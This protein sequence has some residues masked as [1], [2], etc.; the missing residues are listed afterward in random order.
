MCVEELD[1]SPENY[2]QLKSKF[3][4]SLGPCNQPLTVVRNKIESFVATRKHSV[5][6]SDQPH[7]SLRTLTSDSDP[8]MP[9]ETP[10]LTFQQHWRRD[11]TKKHY[12]WIRDGLQY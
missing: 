1:C 12:N 4:Y 8:Q 3:V 6:R 11:L 9:S 5:E 2:A 7:G 10:K